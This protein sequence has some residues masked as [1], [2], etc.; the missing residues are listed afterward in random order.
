MPRTTLQIEDDALRVAKVHA[1]RHRLTLGQAVSE[2]VRQAADRP[3]VTD[4]RNGL[5][6]VHLSRRSPKVTTALVGKLR[7]DRP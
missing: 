7:D 3:L 2:L 5:R 4:A 6:L 1:S